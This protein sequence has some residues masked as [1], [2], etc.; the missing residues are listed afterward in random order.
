MTGWGTVVGIDRK[1]LRG[2]L[3]APLLLAANL[4]FGDLIELSGASFQVNFDADP[5]QVTVE[6]DEVRNT[7]DTRGTGTLYLSL[8]YTGCDAPISFGLGSFTTEDNDRRGLYSLNRVVPGG[9]S[10]LDPGESWRNIR[11]TTGW[12]RPSPGTWRR[13][14]VVYQYNT[15]LPNNGA[16]TQIGAATFSGT[17]V[18][19][20]GDGDNGCLTANPI[21]AN[22][23]R[24]GTIN[25]GGDVDYWRIR[26][27]SRGTLVVGTEGALDTEGHLLDEAGRLIETDDDD[28]PGLNFQVDRTVDAGTYHV[29]VA[30]HTRDTAGSYTLAVRHTPAPPATSPDLVV[31]SPSVDNAN[32]NSGASFTLSV[33]VRNQGG[34][35]ADGTTL[36]YYRSP[37]ATI[38]V[39]SDT[40]VGT[41]F[42]EQLAANGSSSES[43]SLTAPSTAGTYYYGACVVA[44]LDESNI[45]NNCSDGV[46]VTVGGDTGDPIDDFDV[47]IPAGCPTQVEIC[48]RDHQCEDGDEVRVTVNDTVIFSGEIFNY[49]ICE[50]ADVRAGR[51]DIEMYAINGTGFK[52][53]CGHQDVNTGEI[54]VRGNGIV[55]QRW[56]HAGGR[57]SSANLNITVGAS[58]TCPVEDDDHGDT[59]ATAIAVGVPSATA[60]RLETDT[61]NDYF[62]LDVRGPG[63]LTV[64]T[65]SSLDTVGALIREDS[66]D[67]RSNDDSGSGSNFRIETDVTAGTYYVRVGGYGSATG[68]YTLKVEFQGDGG[69]VAPAIPVPRVDR[70]TTTEVFLVWPAVPN[71]T[72]YKVYRQ[73]SDGTRNAFGSYP[74]SQV[75]PFRHY[76]L[77]PGTR[78]CYTVTALNGNAESAHS[79]RVCGTTKSEDDSDDQTRSVGVGGPVTS[80]RLGDLSADGYDDVLLRHVGDGGWRYYAMDGSRGS[81]VGDLG[82]T[83]DLANTFVGVGDLNGDGHDDVLLRHADTGAWTYYAM[84]G[85]P[86]AQARD[87]GLPAELRNRLA[88]IGDFDADGHDDVLLRHSE[89]GA[90]TYHAMGGENAT[91]GL[92]LT[93]NLDYRFAGIG[94]FDADGHDDVLLRH[95]DSGH[96][97]YYAMDGRRGRLLRNLGLT[98][99]FKW[100]L[101]GVGDFDADGHDDVLLRHADSGHWIYYAMDGRSGRL[102]R[103]FGA[104]PNR[105]WELAGV[106]DVN[107]DGYDDIVLRNSASGHWIYYAMNGL[108]STLVRNLGLTPDRNWVPP[109]IALAT[110]ADDTG[111]DPFVENQLDDFDIGLPASCPLEVE[112]CVRDHLCEDGDEVRVTVNSDEV[113]SGELFNARHCVTVPVTEGSNAIEMYA[114]NGTGYKGL[115]NHADVNTGQIDVIGGN[116]QSQTWMH[117]GGTG[118]TASIDVTVGGD[119]PCRPGDDGS[120]DLV[121]ES[122]SVD[123][124][125]VEAG[126]AFTL[127]A[128]VRNRGDGASAATTL[129]YYRSADA[130]ISTGDAAVGTDEVAGLAAGVSTSES[131][132]LTAPGAAG[133]YYYG[134]C[135]D[136]VTGESDRSNNC[137]AAARVTVSV[138]SDEDGGGGIGGAGVGG[139]VT[140]FRLGDLSADGYDDVLL[141]HVGDGGWRYY[142]MDGSRGS[143]V[144]DLGLT[145][146]LANTFVGVGDLNGDGHDDVLLRH[147][148]T[149]AWT[150]YAMDGE[151][152]AQARDPG[153]PAE[154]RNR[155]AGIGDFDADGHDD[156]LLRHSESGAWTYHAMGGENATDGLGLTVNLDYRFAGIGDFDAD[157]HDDVLLRHADSGHWIYYAMD[158]RRGRLLR[159]LGLTP[160]FKWTLAGVGDFDADGYDDVLLRHADSGHWIYYAMDGRSGRLVR[161]FGATPNRDWELAGVGDVNADGYDDI[162]LRNSASGHWIYYAMN[163]LGSTLVRNLGLTP[164]R[165]WVPPAIARATAADDT[166]GGPFVEDQLDDFDIGLPASCPLEVEVCVRDHLCEDGDEVRVTVNS[167]EVFSGEL[168]NARHC[169]TVPVTEGSNAIEMYAI[170]G[171]G[172][173]GLCNHADVNTGQIDVIGGNEQ[174]QS[175]MH[176]GGTGSTASINVTVGGGGSCRPGDDGSPDLVVESPSVDNAS[177]EAGAAFTL[178]ARVRNRGDGA[179]AAT[180]LRYYRSA[181]ATISTGDAA[182]GTDAVAG[183]AAGVS[184]SESIR[185][186]APGAAGTY[187]YGACADAVLDESNISNNCSDG[188]RVTVGGDTG[189]PIDDFDV[190]IPAGCPTQ[191]E[192]CVRDHQCEDGDEVRVTVN[193]TVIFSGEIFNHWICEN[194]DVRAGRN[195]IEMYAINGTGFKGN[196]GHQDVNTGEIRVRGNGIVTQRWEHAGGRGSSANLNITVGASGTCPIEDD[197]HGDTQATATAVGV[198]SATAGRLETDTDNDYFRLEVRGSGTLKVYTESSIDTVGELIRGGSVDT[199]TDDD[200]GAGSNF[201]IEAEVTAG[202]YYVR[203]GGFGSEIGDYTLHVEYQGTASSPDLV[204][205]SPSVDNAS[206]EAG[207]AFTLSARVRNRGDGASAATTLRYYRSA[208]ATISTGD[209]AVGTDAVAGLAAGVSTS[210]SIGLTAPGAAGTYYYGACADAVTGESDSSNNCSGAVRVTVSVDSDEDGGGGIGGAGVGGPV[211]SFRLGDLSADGYDDVLLRHVGDGG[212]RYY[213]MDGSRGSLVGDLGLT[214]DLANTFVGVGD[215]NGDGHDD[216]LLRH[217]D[218][219]AWTYYAMDGEPGAQARDPGLPAELR[220]RLAGIGDFDADGHDDALLRHSESGAWTY[221]AMGGENATDGLGLTVNLDYRFAGIGDFDADGHDDVLLRHADSGHWIYYAMDGRRGRLLRNLGLTPDFKWALAGVGDFDADGYDDVL[222]RHADSG[223]WIYYAM[224]GRSGRLVRNFGAT[225]NRDWALAGVGDVNADG[226]DDIVLRNS[227][228]GHWIYYAMNGLGS[229]LVR[230]LGLTPDRNWVPPAIARATAADDTGGGPFVED[231]LDDFDIGLPASCPLELEVCVRDHLCED[232]DEVRVT[233]NSDEVFSGELFNARHCVTVPV[234]EGSNA[235]EMYAINGTGYKGLCNHADVNTGQIDVI[236]GNEQSQTWMHRGGTG[237]TAS[238]NVTVGGGGSCRPGDD[239]DDTP[240]DATALPIGGTADGTLDGPNDVD[241]WRIEV[242]SQGEVTIESTGSTDTLGRLEDSSGNQL[243]EDD[244]SGEGT[245]FRIVLDL[246]PGTYYVRVSGAASAAGAY[247]VRVSHQPAEGVT[248]S[249]NFIGLGERGPS[250]SSREIYSS[251]DGITW[252]LRHH[253]APGEEHQY[254]LDDVVHGDGLWVVVGNRL[255]PEAPRL[256]QIVLTSVDGR[257]WTYDE[258]HHTDRYGNEQEGFFA[259]AYGDQRWTKVGG[260]GISTSTDGRTWSVVYDATNT[261]LGPPTGVAY[262]DGLWIAVSGRTVWESG[263][264]TEWRVLIEPDWPCNDYMFKP[265]VEFGGGHW[266]G[267]ARETL[268]TRTA[269]GGWTPFITEDDDVLYSASSGQGRLAYGNGDWI[270]GEPWRGGL[271]IWQGGSNWDIVR[272]DGRPDSFVYSQGVWYAYD[273]GGLWVNRDNPRNVEDWAPHS[274]VDN[275]LPFDSLD[276]PNIYHVA[277]KR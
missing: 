142:A 146:D 112:I 90:W 86:G 38:S 170:N 119:G 32:P 167:D 10:R 53:N 195:D 183:L 233:V 68:D 277:A 252:N 225:P 30:G 110:A 179:S 190:T 217:A 89:S 24:S 125:S 198:P 257:N 156:V 178:S 216:V 19:P 45:S 44:V 66:G 270:G 4:V 162:V 22:G 1:R 260:K 79:A 83:G 157:G 141:R 220:N 140:S 271:F 214:G 133:T 273:S 94:D 267:G 226:Y 208:D 36:R 251:E 254:A 87:P 276:H 160:D 193:D 215:L 177:V 213:A 14:L 97:I 173:K 174:S 275:D 129:R 136:A 222:L 200:S 60:G 204:V 61:D 37:D 120:P 135:A 245:N 58:G 63:K 194:A 96:W 43:I 109:A 114:I 255:K 70:V 118:S 88:G 28:G 211:T 219:G 85:G 161:N 134:A 221:H 117:R 224:D 69:A 201:R 42:V 67:L 103:N 115:C 99:D 18:V 238:I 52:G 236:G 6:V 264:G 187:Y 46:R 72:H 240:A 241:Y 34:S 253:F 130:T 153:L 108:G 123:N 259:V 148:D 50:N 231:Q 56:E 210:E 116:E 55:T 188:V 102:V 150:Y 132:R 258:F 186:T 17:Y 223:H 262:G 95:A 143:L 243:A 82:L 3:G 105:D 185:L 35:G 11:F 272:L 149:G 7:S 113:F 168:F 91:D 154:L 139:P 207:A 169:V 100:A 64:Y 78:Y 228:S 62:R 5:D 77:T 81:L 137:S 164:D 172:Y 249:V 80:F 247:S 25:A 268:C 158:G 147:A 20:G 128:R 227:A 248:D 175:W 235:I 54:R 2:A 126:A 206:V 23:R 203:V 191:V 165:N 155:L 159:N 31:E 8:R 180:T 9:D 33:R 131:I 218:T 29:R 256:W 144:G 57:G 171:T 48:V 21:D 75:P 230:N 16:T 181:D 49:W 104:T 13:H 122:P 138:D 93:V 101:A 76:G 163:G 250:G 124:A 274:V 92:G 59:Q 234:T 202:T 106:G 239:G 47:T 84:D 107:A 145:G 242:P 71:A 205:E 192:I 244:D 189:D 232:G 246:D 74:A 40:V 27:P 51:N 269:G 151:P 212:W 261:D 266:Y 199:D 65:E 229:T 182:V 12:R 39:V 121:V 237:S 111:G 166:G 152:G 41:G 127:S 196:C 209:A 98:P 15:S 184:T 265:M 197:D 176:R 26:V 263:N 73:L